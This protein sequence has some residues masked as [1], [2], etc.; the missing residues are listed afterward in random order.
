[1]RGAALWDI[2]P[3]QVGVCDGCLIGL[4]SCNASIHDLRTWYG[5]VCVVAGCVRRLCPHSIGAEENVIQ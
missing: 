5:A 1:M 2:G 4:C 3:Q